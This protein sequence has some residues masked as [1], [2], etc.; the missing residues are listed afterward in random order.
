MH[1]VPLQPTYTF[2]TSVPIADIPKSKGGIDAMLVDHIGRPLAHQLT[3][4][5]Y[6][7][8]DMN[9]ILE[10]SQI[11]V[12]TITEPEH[13]IFLVVFPHPAGE[14]RGEMH[15]LRGITVELIGGE[16]DGTRPPVRAE[17]HEQINYT[18][19]GAKPGEH[20]ATYRRTGYNLA[21]GSWSYQY[22]KQSAKPKAEA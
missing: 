21:D 1:T 6:Q 5:G 3:E 9:T 13:A 15:P 19:P 12:D 14:K 8:E 22:V 10:G 17:Q 7:V 16:H 4:A 2:S 11:T 18:A 20:T